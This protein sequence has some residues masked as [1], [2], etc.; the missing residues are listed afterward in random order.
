ME[1]ST[2]LQ[3]RTRS[4]FFR[5]LNDDLMRLGKPAHGGVRL[6][7]CECSRP[8]C[9]ETLVVGEAEYE[10]VR[11]HEARYFIVPGHELTGVQRVV[12]RTSRAAV[13]Q[14]RRA[15][16][17]VGNG[18]AALPGVPPVV[19]VVDDDPAVRTLVSLNLQLEGLR[20]LEAGDGRRGLE[21]AQRA[22]PALV[23]TDVRMPE[24]DGFGLGRALRR[25]ERTRRIPLIF[26]SGEAEAANATRARRLGALAYVLKPF[27]VRAFSAL[28][29]GVVARFAASTRIAASG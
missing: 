21:L 15:P 20:V 16:P 26:V 2:E 11:A 28:V 29:A 10:A 1:G 7:V 22:L 18:A 23:V 4:A 14:E 3:P 9:A 13:V 24:L 25:D 17:A 27:D 6:I 5:A 19:L 12:E 8:R